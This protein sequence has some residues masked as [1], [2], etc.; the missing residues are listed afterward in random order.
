MASKSVLSP[1]DLEYDSID[2]HMTEIG[3]D[4]VVQ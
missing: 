2:T 4:L 3:T 1:S